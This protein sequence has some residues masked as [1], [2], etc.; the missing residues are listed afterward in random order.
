MPLRVA[1]VGIDVLG[2]RDMVP[3]HWPHYSPN[4]SS[5]EHFGMNLTK[6]YLG[7]GPLRKTPPVATQ[8]QNELIKDLHY[9]P[10]PTT[11][12]L[13]SYIRTKIRSGDVVE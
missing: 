3:I 12:K 6:G 1:M 7:D 5:F 4:W 2:N 9:V 8:L 10:I 13:K 11:N